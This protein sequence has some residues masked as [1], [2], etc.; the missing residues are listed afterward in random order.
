MKKSQIWDGNLCRKVIHLLNTYQQFHKNQL[1]F[2]LKKN[3]LL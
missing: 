1:I 3:I 2:H